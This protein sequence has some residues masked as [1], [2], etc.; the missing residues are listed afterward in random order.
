MLMRYFFLLF[1]T[2]TAL[3]DGDPVQALTEKELQTYQFSNP[4]KIT[5]VTV[6]ELNVG[7]QFTLDKDRREF[8]NLLHRQLGIRQLSGDRSDL[9][10]IQQVIDKKMLTAD[11]VREWQSVGVVF[12]DILSKEFGLSWI[13]YE[14]EMGVS[15]ALRWRST[16]N[17]VFP[18]TLFSKRIRFKQKI[19]VYEVYDKLHGE[20]NVFKQLP[21]PVAG[22][23]STR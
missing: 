20:I 12:G 13:S 8:T 16:E 19:D 23:R 1:L 21:A 4:A 11:Q 5:Q 7:Q 2:A 17:Y 9:K 3:A 10:S 14:D 15:K 18:I 6:K 22:A